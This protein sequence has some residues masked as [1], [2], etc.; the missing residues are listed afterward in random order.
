MIEVTDRSEDSETED[1]KRKG[2][3]PSGKLYARMINFQTLC[4]FYAIN[5]VQA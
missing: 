4:T 1:T 2:H 3:F 5:N